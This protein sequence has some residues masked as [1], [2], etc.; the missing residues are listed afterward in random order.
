MLDAVDTSAGIRL[1]GVGVTALADFV[2]DD[3]FGGAGGA[4]PADDVV[5]VP[6]PAVPVAEATPP[7]WRPGQ[8]VHHDEH[9]PGWVWGSGLGRVSV[10]FEGPGTPPG[11]VRTFAVDDARLRPA[12]PPDWSHGLGALPRT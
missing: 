9:G 6:R 5:T 12:D 10:R 7:S 4:E 3:L 2:Q 8:D 11:P 1:L